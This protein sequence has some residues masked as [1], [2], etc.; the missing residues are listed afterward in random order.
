[1]ILIPELMYTSRNTLV[2]ST[3]V[4]RILLRYFFRCVSFLCTEFLYQCAELPNV[5]PITVR[6]I[7]MALKN[8]RPSAHL[9]APRYDK[10]N[11]DY[12]SQVLQWRHQLYPLP[13]F[14]IPLLFS[15][16]SQQYA[17][18]DVNLWTCRFCEMY[19]YV[20]L[21]AFSFGTSLSNES[22]LLNFHF[23]F[24]SLSL[25]RLRMSRDK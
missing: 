24:P 17:S 3:C 15:W 9:H 13:F 1:M 10:F 8:T 5:G 23:G 21:C 25:S 19:D 12:G 18:A 22:S 2:P 14:I 6:D 7:E 20:V 11:S 4:W 16:A